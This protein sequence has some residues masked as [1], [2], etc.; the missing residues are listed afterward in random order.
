MNLPGTEIDRILDAALAED[1]PGGDVTTNLLFAPGET[2]TAVF[3]AKAAGVIAGLPV[4][5][6]VFQRLDGAAH[7]TAHVEDGARVPSGTALARVTC[8]RRALLTGERVAL[9]LLQRMSGIATMASQ[10]AEAV[11]GLPV[12]LLDTRKTAP[13]L[14][15]LD[16]YAVRMGGVTNHRLTLTDLAM[17]KDNHIKLAGGIAPAVARVRAGAPA[18]LRIE[19]E[20]G[21]LDDVRAALAA[22]ADI[23][24]LDNMDLATMRAAV[25]LAGV[26]VELEASGN[27]SLETIRAVAETGVTSISIGRL[28]HSPPALDISMKVA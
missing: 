7:F 1:A 3:R 12:R 8:S 6:R 20:C 23:V 5:E 14:R 18:G 9:N 4:A 22:G 17:I 27:I 2:G 25:A 16:K 15:V 11:A 28:T 13:G 21:S 26:R 10:Y 19:V 24:M